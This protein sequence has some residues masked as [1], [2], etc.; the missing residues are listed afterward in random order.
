MTAQEFIQWL[1]PAAR[2]LCRKYSL[3]ASV[4]VAQG[5]LE[6]GWGQYIIGQYN[7]FGRKWNGAGAYVEKTTQEYLDGEW[8]TIVDRFQD[9]ANLEEAVEDWCILLTEEPVYALCLDYRFDLEQ[10]VQM[11]GPI[12]ATD[13]D[14]AGKLLSIVRTYRLEEWDR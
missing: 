11:L 12:Y 2:D 6:S 8:Q 5:A 9:Y 4:C 3:L 10:F 1:G 13:P 14:Y 7:L